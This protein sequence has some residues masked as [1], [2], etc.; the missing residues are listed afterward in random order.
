MLNTTQTASALRETLSWAMA[1]FALT[2]LGPFT[3]PYAIDIAANEDGWRPWL[4]VAPPMAG[5]MV[6]ALA[7]IKITDPLGTALQT[8]MML[9]IGVMI[10]LAE[11]A[12]FKGL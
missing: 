3:L 7:I 8:A 11:R 10:V 1:A 4:L 5:L 2:L 6:Y 12:G 9:L